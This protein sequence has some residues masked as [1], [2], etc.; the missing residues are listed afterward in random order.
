MLS[1]VCCVVLV[2]AQRGPMHVLT[3][4]SNAQCTTSGAAELI[5]LTKR[6][7]MKLKECMCACAEKSFFSVNL[8]IDFSKPSYCWY[9]LSGS[10]GRASA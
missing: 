4:Q 1:V 10:V 3:M 9:V 6:E 5:V 7:I 2:H 8:N